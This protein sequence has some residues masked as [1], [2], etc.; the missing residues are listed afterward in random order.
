MVK[1]FES[2]EGWKQ[3]LFSLP[4]HT[5]NNGGQS[6]TNRI[7]KRERR[8][9]PKKTKLKM[10]IAD[11]DIISRKLILKSVGEFGKRNNQPKL[12]VQL[13]GQR[14]PDVD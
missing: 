4:L 10:L 3:L 6:Q 14:E 8:M 9:Y 13:K 7:E 12:G 1:S 11:D 2:Q 5:K